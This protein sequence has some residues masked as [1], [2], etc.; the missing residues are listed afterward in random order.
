ME[1]G[2]VHVEP[3]STQLIERYLDSRGLRFYRS[4]DG[5]GLLVLFS[6]EHGK[7]QANLR[8][9]G[10][11]SDILVISISTA[12]YSRAADRSRLTEL[13]NDWNRDTH[14]PKAFVRDTSQRGRIAVVGESAFP[15]TDGIHL[16]GL[17]NFINCSIRG[18]SKLFDKVAQATG[19]PSAQTLEEWLDRTG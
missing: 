1:G 11:R 18:G 15:L 8:V 9:S 6:T 7:L 10:V 16:D 13:V 2:L 14:W 17:G 5:K 3:L 4:Q 19:V 12:T